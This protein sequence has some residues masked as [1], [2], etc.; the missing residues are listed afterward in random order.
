MVIFR[1]TRNGRSTHAR[2]A[3]FAMPTAVIILFIITLLLAAAVKVAS[4]TSTS[5][6]RDSNVKAEIEAAEGGLQVATY[7]LS[8]LEPTSTQCINGAEAL[9]ATTVAE[10]E[11]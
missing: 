3:G 6:T 7:R 2:D 4:Q 9:T 5:T 11:A 8:Q 1:H 10:A